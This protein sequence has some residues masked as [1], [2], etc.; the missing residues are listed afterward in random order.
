MPELLV[1]VY[2]V[3]IDEQSS[4]TPSSTGNQL[5]NAATRPAISHAVRHLNAM[6]GIMIT[7]SHNAPRYN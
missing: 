6:G 2:R 7:A 3:V 1:S 4:R 5:I